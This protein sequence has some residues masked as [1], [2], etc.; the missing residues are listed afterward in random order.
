MSEAVQYLVTLSGE[1]HED[2]IPVFIGEPQ[3]VIDELA[4][5]E[6]FEY[7]TPAEIEAVL[8]AIPRGDW[9]SIEGEDGMSVG[10]YNILPNTSIP[11]T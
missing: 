4:K 8:D 1:R 11:R 9:G 2:H 6:G 3:R 10:I 7:I 5:T